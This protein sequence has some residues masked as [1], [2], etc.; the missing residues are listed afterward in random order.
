MD[1]LRT[2]INIHVDIPEEFYE[3]AIGH[4]SEYPISGIEEKNDE[5]VITMPS[6]FFSETTKKMIQDDLWLVY[7]KAVISKTEEIKDENWNKQWEETISPIIIN[8]EIAISPEWHLSE[9]KQKHIIIINPKM[10]FGTGHHATTRMVCSMMKENITQDSNWIDAGT[11]TG[12]L[13]ILAVKLGAKSVLAFDNDEWSV[14]NTIENIELNKCSDKIQ[15]LQSGLLEVNLPE[16][17]GIT[18][19]LYTH[20]LKPAFPKF[21]KALKKRKG[22]LLISGVLVYDKDE[23]QR[24]TTDAGFRHIKTIQEDE[25]IAMHLSTGE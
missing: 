13:A 2:Y 25:W 14:D 11:G 3:F 6:P 12:V 8:D 19:N 20:L 5:L 4:L 1:D 9:I 18:A 10:S 16:S 21:Y 7:D 24:A 22:T 23:I 15:V 17:D